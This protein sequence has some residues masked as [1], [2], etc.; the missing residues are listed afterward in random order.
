MWSDYFEQALRKIAIRNTT[1]EP[2]F[3]R[4]AFGSS[5]LI[6]RSHWMSG[7]STLRRSQ[8]TGRPFSMPCWPSLRV[9]NQR[10]PSLKEAAQSP[11]PEVARF[12]SLG[13]SEPRAGALASQGQFP[14]DLRRLKG[15][16]PPT[17][18]LYP[19]MDSWVSRPLE[20]RKTRLTVVCLIRFPSAASLNRS[21]TVAE[22]WLQAAG[23]LPV[24]RALMNPSGDLPPLQNSTA[25]NDRR[26]QDHADR[27]GPGALPRAVAVQTRKARAGRSGQG[28]EPDSW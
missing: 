19:E 24:R 28:E 6:A 20:S 18:M 26:S 3:A 27:R 2:G 15:D 23:E 11:T 12:T 4:R 14:L 17:Q 1:L 25:R 5:D 16:T 7:S 13:G 8:S 9:E 10:F 22:P 21:R